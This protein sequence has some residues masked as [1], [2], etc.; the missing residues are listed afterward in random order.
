MENRTEATA[1]R[2]RDDTVRRVVELF[3]RR[4]ELRGVYPMA[5][6][7]AESLSWTV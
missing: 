5:D 4:E 7:M 2:R 1:S 6:H 3:D